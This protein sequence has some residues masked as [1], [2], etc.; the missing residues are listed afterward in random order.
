MSNAEL[1]VLDLRRDCSHEMID[2]QCC[3]PRYMS[4]QLTRRVSSRRR[5]N[6]VAFGAERI[7]SEARLQNWFRSTQPSPL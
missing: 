1:F 3:L 6:S 7:F 2:E 5:I 4:Q